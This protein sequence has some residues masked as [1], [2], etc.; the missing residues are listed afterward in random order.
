MSVRLEEDA[1]LNLG[2]VSLQNLKKT[3]DFSGFCDFRLSIYTDLY[4]NRLL[5]QD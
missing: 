5:K 2:W 1:L 4:S 3:A